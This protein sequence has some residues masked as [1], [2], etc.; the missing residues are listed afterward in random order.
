MKF[1]KT[2]RRIFKRK[3]TITNAVRTGRIMRGYSAQKTRGGYIAV[4]K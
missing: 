2:G 1:T 4:K 3:S